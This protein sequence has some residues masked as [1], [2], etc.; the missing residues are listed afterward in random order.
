MYQFDS[1]ADWSLGWVLILVIGA[2]ASVFVAA[3]KVMR[4]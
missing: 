2:L 1:I 4:Q 3:R